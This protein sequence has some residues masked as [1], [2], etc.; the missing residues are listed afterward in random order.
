[1]PRRD[2][3]ILPGVP[4]HV[5]QR[6]VDRRETFSSAA[7]RE[8]YRALLR[9]NLEDAVVGLLAWCLMTNHVHLIATPDREDSLSVLLRRV[10]G[11]YAQYY[12]ARW[13]RSGHLWQNRYFACSLGPGHLWAA[14]AY[15]EKNPVRAGLVARA[16]EYPWSSAPAHLGLVDD[17][18]LVDLEWWRRELGGVN[19]SE[20]LDGQDLEQPAELRRCTY[21]GRPFGDEGFVK[22]ISEQFGRHWVRGRPRKEPTSPEAADGRQ[23]AMFA[24]PI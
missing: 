7:D 17:G 13:A 21:S 23:M 9:Q 5:T 10:H 14:L 3:C 22:A 12:N 11:R 16:G 1:M 20:R 8:I 4:C 24:E 15:V 19:W 18:G 2:R 6:G